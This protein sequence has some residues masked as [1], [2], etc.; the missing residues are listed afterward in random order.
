M[1]LEL[2]TGPLGNQSPGING[3]TSKGENVHVCYLAARHHTLAYGTIH[4]HTNTGLQSL[5]TMATTPAQVLYF[6]YNQGEK[7]QVKSIN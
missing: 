7:R 4:T 2:A 5:I 1:R 6:Y 3:F